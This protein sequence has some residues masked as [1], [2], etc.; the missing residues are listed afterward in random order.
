MTKTIHVR[1]LNEGTDVSRPTEGREIEEGLYEIIPT[2]DYNPADE[3]WEFPP[4]SFVRISK[5]E[6]DYGEYF[7]AVRR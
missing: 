4:G 5:R 1:L 7:M 6:T 2:A 3:E